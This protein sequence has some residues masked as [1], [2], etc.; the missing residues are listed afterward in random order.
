MDVYQLFFNKI[1]GGVKQCVLDERIERDK[2]GENNSSETVT[3]R[4]GHRF[5]DYSLVMVKGL[6]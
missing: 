4:Y 2:L 6:A 5:M 1:G 3:H